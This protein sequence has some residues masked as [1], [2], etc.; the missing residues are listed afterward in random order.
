MAFRDL[1]EF[2]AALDARGEL[3]RITAP[4]SVDLEAAEIAIQSGD[5]A[6]VAQNPVRP[7]LEQARK[8][9]RLMEA[10]DEHDDVTSVS[11]NCDL[12]EELM[13]ELSAN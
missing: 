12:P 9:L 1:R 6:M 11:S 10:L 8:V 5:V 2:L 7:G 13:A 4:V 3:K